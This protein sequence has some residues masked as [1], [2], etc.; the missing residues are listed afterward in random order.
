MI[1]AI[2]SEILVS[3]LFWINNKNIDYNEAKDYYISYNNQQAYVIPD[4]YAALDR[5]GGKKVTKI[6]K[7]KLYNFLKN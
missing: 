7:K 6:S 2:C 3:G 1:E 4:S 5:C